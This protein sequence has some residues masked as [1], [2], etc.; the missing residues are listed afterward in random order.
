MTVKLNFSQNATKNMNKLKQA[1]GV[2]T[3]EELVQRALAVLDMLVGEKNKGKVIV[4]KNPDR[5]EVKET[6]L[7]LE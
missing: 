7:N 3:D 5:A 4:S 2:D 6:I 1:I